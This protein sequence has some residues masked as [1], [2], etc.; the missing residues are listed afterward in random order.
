MSKDTKTGES[1]EMERSR[2]PV[3]L[4]PPAYTPLSVGQGRR[5]ISYDV[6]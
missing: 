6:E 3:P 1:W 2:D 4:P 5:S